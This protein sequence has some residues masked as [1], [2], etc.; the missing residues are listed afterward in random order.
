MYPWTESQGPVI[1]GKLI[2]KHR[3][4][5][6]LKSLTLKFNAKIRCSWHEKRGNSTVHYSAKL[7]LV[8]KTW[9]FLEKSDSKLHLLRA[10][11][12]YTY[13]FQLVL[14]I[15]L[16]NSLNTSTGKIEYMFSANGKRS[17]FQLDLDRER[18]VEIYQSL[19]PQH[20]HCL[21]PQQQTADFERAFNY[22]VQIPRKAFHH[23]AAIP[24]TVRMQ[25]LMGSGV[26]WRVKEMNMKIK[27]YVWFIS[28][29][30]GMKH[31][32]Q[33]LV[34]AKQ[35]SGTWPVQTGLVERTLSINMPTTNVLST[36]D[37]ELIKCTHKLKIVFNLEINGSSKKLVADFDIY[38]PGP[39]PPGQGPVGVAPQPQPQPQPQQ[40]Q[41]Q[42]LQYQHPLP[43]VPVQPTYQQQ[44]QQPYPGYAPLHQQPALPSGVPPTQPVYAAQ[45]QSYTVAPAHSYAAPMQPSTIPQSSGHAP[46]PSG[47]VSSPATYGSSVQT[48][49]SAYSNPFSPHQSPH[50]TQALAYP[51]PPPT[52]STPV[53]TPAMSAAAATPTA[54]HT[55]PV[56][57]SSQGYPTPAMPP[58]PSPKYSNYPMPPSPGQ[59]NMS[60]TSP[61]KVPSPALHNIPMPVPSPTPAVTY[62]TPAVSSSPMVPPKT[63]VTN[64]Q[65]QQNAYASPLPPVPSSPPVPVM[66]ETTITSS[67]QTILDS[68]KVGSSGAGTSQPLKIDDSI[69]VD[70]NIDDTIKV[71]LDDIKTP[72]TPLVGGASGAITAAVAT[73]HSK[74]PQQRH[75]YV[76]V[77]NGGGENGDLGQVAQEQGQNQMAYQPPPPVV[78]SQSQNPHAIK[79]PDQ[80]LNQFSHQLPPPPA[81]TSSSASSA[82]APTSTTYSTNPYAAAVAAVAVLSGP[83]SSSTSASVI[84][85]KEN[86][87]TQQF[88]QMG[89]KAP[90]PPT[91]VTISSAAAMTSSPTTNF[92]QPSP[93]ATPTALHNRTSMS[94]P[95]PMSPVSAAA[96]GAVVASQQQQQQ[97]HQ[98]QQQQL[99]QLQQQQQQ[100]PYPA[101]S[102]LQQ[103]QQHHRHHH[104]H[105]NAPPPIQTRK[106]QI[107]IPMYQTLNGKVYVQYILAP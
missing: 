37:T 96:T 30:K 51:P 81:P 55:Y 77:P 63:P 34:E 24:I 64:F 79:K 86:E 65:Q 80:D 107:W 20:P 57:T 11:Q 17:T 23:G 105:L 12:P 93:L 28:P 56:L 94:Y 60:A 88:S 98:Q 78:P 99:Q 100:Q 10:N 53:A 85:H 73:S 31:E 61:A 106:Q 75:S 9:V 72:S 45:Q 76:G 38:V 41:Q 39:F 62:V 36:I 49:S 18:L 7:P 29:G 71:N 103:Q 43:P 21:Y 42:Q 83:L 22:V 13:N 3:D 6:T 59:A 14:P 87:L 66:T 95:H 54:S 70:A 101:H 47:Y 25:P 35:G 97:Q 2:V 84:K 19:P 82:T 74:N 8:E 26:Q 67:Y 89:F 5:V 91:P 27:E 46:S 48:P 1:N 16:P 44:Q 33:S 68:P 92:S 15:N 69:K 104:H 52:Y 58:M 50:H 102:A 4:D 90:P 40:Q 32:K